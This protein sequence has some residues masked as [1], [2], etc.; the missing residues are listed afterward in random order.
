MFRVRCPMCHGELSIDP[1]TRAV[2]SHR[3]PEQM[4]QAPSEQME[5]LLDKVR[6][7]KAEQESKLEAAR[8]RESKRKEHV[9]DLFRR[10][11]EKAR[12][13]GDDGKPV[14]PVW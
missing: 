5:S 10:A 13:E 12:E 3:T 8:E 1:R 6:K 14:G 2:V 11:Q 7:S 9:E 4:Q